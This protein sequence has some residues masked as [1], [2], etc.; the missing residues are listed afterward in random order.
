MT[1]HSVAIPTHAPE[2]EEHL[3]ECPLFR[4]LT[5]EVQEQCRKNTHLL[6]YIHALPTGQLGVPRY[7]ATLS[8][9]LGDM[10]P[11]NLLYPVS[12]EVFIHVLTAPKE[13]R[14][15]YIPVEPLFAVRLDEVLPAVEARLLDKAEKFAAAKT[16]EEKTQALLSALDE[17][18]QVG[19]GSK[20]SQT[21]P[22]GWFF[23]RRREENGKV[24]LTPQQFA[25]VRYLMVRDKVGLGVLQPMIS[26]KYIEDISCSGLGYVFLEHKIFK[27]MKSTI[28]FATHEQ[29]DKFVLR[30]SEQIK[31]P[32]TL[33]NPIVDATLP[34][35][36]RVNIVYGREVSQRG[37]NFTIRKFNE[38]PLSIFE[39]IEFGTMDYRMAAY[40]SILLEEGMNIFVSGETASGKTTALNAITIFVPPDAKIVTIEDT[41]EIQ[42][43]HQNWVREVAKAPRAG[44]KGAAVTM[45]DLLKA[46]LRQRPNLIMIG[47]IRGEEGAIA[48]QAMQ[49]GHAVMAT[50]HASTVERLI[51]RLTG[52]PINIPKTYIDNLNA[53]VIMSAVR[54]PNGKTGRR[55]LSISEIVGYDP[56]SNTFSFVE[57]FRWDPVRDAF[58]F[59]GDKNSFL[60]EQKVAMRRGLVGNRKWEIYNLLE[61]RAR[62][63]E[64]L[65]KEK[66]VKGYYDLFRILTQAR[67][68]GL[69]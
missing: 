21:R 9:K 1:T 34:D 56:P 58:E 27:S 19:N 55:A 53:V 51:Q 2:T 20:T 66:G 7:Y 18:C 43:P 28:H 62:V 44:E 6:R 42:V 47:E 24:T 26:D 23:L 54:L 63:L 17:V 48:F 31:R 50:F 13:E 37:S 15:L 67:R 33:R 5:P 22:K 69:F 3:F 16:P 30:L 64:K 8:R 57:V 59:V 41:P 45:M 68:E 35:G 32:V 49:T 39:L 61:R 46:A 60:L 29:L 36:S 65:H 40:L 14:S 4:S 38:T 52:H 11:Y 12:E 10:K 25:A